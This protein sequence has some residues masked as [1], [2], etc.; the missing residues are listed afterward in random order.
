MIK[1]VRYWFQLWI[2]DFALLSKL[3]E[4]C[5]FFEVDFIKISKDKHYMF[6]PLITRT[7]VL[8]IF[9]FNKNNHFIFSFN[10]NYFFPKRIHQRTTQIFTKTIIIG[11]LSKIKIPKHL[12]CYVELKYLFNWRS[13]LSSYR[14]LIKY[15][16]ITFEKLTEIIIYHLI[17]F[18][19][20]SLKLSRE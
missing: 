7:W 15:P 3:I 8:C 9:N 13:E 19:D 10:K 6:N 4:I 5:Q 20:I 17:T 1:V 16:R 18:N 11:E 12:L 2:L 14:L